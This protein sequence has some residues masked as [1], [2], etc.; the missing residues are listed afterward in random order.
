MPQ[1]L[2]PVIQ[3]LHDTFGKRW[4]LGN[5]T[6]AFSEIRQVCDHHAGAFACKTMSGSSRHRSMFG[7]ADPNFAGLFNQQGTVWNLQ[8]LEANALRLM[9]I[10]DRAYLQ[11]EEDV[12]NKREAREMQAYLKDCMDNACLSFKKMSGVPMMFCVPRRNPLLRGY[13][14]PPGM[15]VLAHVI[16]L[17][18]SLLSKNV[19]IS[20]FRSPWR[21]V[22]APCHR[23][24]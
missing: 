3:Q 2:P 20:R 1:Y 9:Q 5:S 4:N 22:P 14:Q 15:H 16:Q 8:E 17:F 6:F 18:L 7:T 19:L 13:G 21:A 23:H 24:A 10:L 12:F 11:F